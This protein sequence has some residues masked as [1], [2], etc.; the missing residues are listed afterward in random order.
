[1]KNI[2]QSFYGRLS[3]IFLFLLL[4]LG[5]VQI[6]FTAHT[7]SNY[8]REA[9]QRLNLNLAADMAREI[10][11]LLQ[12]SAAIG[13]IGNTIHYIMVLNPKIEIYVLDEQGKIL[14]FFADPNKKVKSKYVNLKPVQT[15][16]GD[17]FTIPILGD[18]PRH[19]GTQKPF[20][21]ASLK[22]GKKLNGYLYVI[23]G[24]EQ[25]DSAFD[26]IRENYITKTLAGGLLVTLFFTGLIGLI[27]F[28]WLTRPLRR[29]KEVVQKFEQ[30][31]FQ[32]RV[33]LKGKDEMGKLGATFNSMAQTIV[34]NME[35]LKEADQQRRQL[36][37][38]ISHDLRTPLASICGY[39]ETI[40]IKDNTLSKEE[41]QKYL[42]V[43]HD[44]A[45]KME[46]LVEQLLDLSKLDARQ[47]KPQM[48]PFSIKDLI[49]DVLMKFKPQA[50]KS[51][52]KIEI[53]VPDGLPQV[54]ADIGLIERVL[55]NLV[56]NALRYTPSG[57]SVT[58][59]AIQNNDQIEIKVRD[60]GSGIPQKD[61][62]H[63][64]DRFFRIEKS[65]GT[66]T[67]G[68]GLGLAIVKKILEIHNSS[69]FVNSAVNAGS[70]FLF[71]LAVWAQKA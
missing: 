16:L 26:T 1:M 8:Y 23:L 45:S 20:S 44:T 42:Q 41:R 40:Q 43:I 2:F 67:G 17:H 25:Y 63:I 60:T 11:P 30:G 13:S 37:A 5:T 64:F 58:I 35:Q 53:D 6:V 27:L 71:N 62:P 36:I 21:A 19:P 28:F 24:G 12:D 69:I 68:T 9:D 50:D 4:V 22:I 49:Y 59:G 48:E 29:M 39:S 32:Q 10:E 52:I 7:W 56:D 18:D 33:K 15:F 55:S 3:L 47:V 54:Y 38:N 66:I 14:A 65:R 61:I 34:Y 31:Q 70:T 51:G 46:E 57:G